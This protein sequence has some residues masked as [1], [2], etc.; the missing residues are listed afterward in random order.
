[1]RFV[2]HRIDDEAAIFYDGKAFIAAAIETLVAS[3]YVS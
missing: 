1:M 2:T 3:I